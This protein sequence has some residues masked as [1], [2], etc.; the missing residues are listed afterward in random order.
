MKSPIILPNKHI[1]TSDE[2]MKAL[3]EYGIALKKFT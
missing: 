2:W 3:G 1:L